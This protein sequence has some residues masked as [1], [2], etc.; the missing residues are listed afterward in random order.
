MGKDR[1]I[2][3]MRR[4]K[5]S[6]TEGHSYYEAKQSSS[7]NIAVPRLNPLYC[8]EVLNHPA[9]AQKELRRSGL[10]QI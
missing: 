3:R 4:S 6:R 9:R 7:G 1:I 8:G 2:Q 10:I 5:K